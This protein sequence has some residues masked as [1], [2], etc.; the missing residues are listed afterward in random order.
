MSV[1]D[2]VELV[3]KRREELYESNIN[4]ERCM[5]ELAKMIEG[6]DEK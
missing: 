6:I 2:A 1:P 5:G 4:G 3:R